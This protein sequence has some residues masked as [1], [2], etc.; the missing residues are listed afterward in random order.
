MITSEIKALYS[1]AGIRT[2]VYYSVKMH[3]TGSSVC[4]TMINVNLEILPLLP[5]SSGHAVAWLV[6]TL[7]YKPQGRGFDSR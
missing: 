3:R 7:C 2:H 4:E 5:E 6:E 1:S